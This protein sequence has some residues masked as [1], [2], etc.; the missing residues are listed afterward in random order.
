M[1]ANLNGI[2]AG[3]EM[4]LATQNH[5]HSAI[6]HVCPM[7]PQPGSQRIGTNVFHVQSSSVHRFQIVGLSQP[8]RF[9]VARKKHI[10]D[11]RGTNSTVRLEELSAVGGL[12]PD[13]FPR[14]GP[15]FG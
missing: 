2:H 8:V 14:Q 7:E 3:E 12:L 9:M 15:S 13:M 5:D 10:A 4:R 11:L 6:G 1:L